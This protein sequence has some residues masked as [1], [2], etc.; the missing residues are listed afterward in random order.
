MMFE[1]LE[2]FPQIGG[3]QDYQALTPGEKILY[4]QYVLVKLEEKAKTPACPLFKR[5]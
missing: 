3:I 5:K 4:N 2:L 1:V